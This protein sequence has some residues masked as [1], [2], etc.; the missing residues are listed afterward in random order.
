[1]CIRG[2]CHSSAVLPPLI[3]GCPACTCWPIPLSVLSV[4]ISTPLIADAWQQ[5][6]QAHPDREWISYLITSIWEEFRIGLLSQPRCHSMAGSYPSATSQ[7]EVIAAFLATQVQAGYI[8]GPLLAYLCTGVITSHM[9]VFPKIHL[10]NWT[11][12]LQTTTASMTTL[13]Y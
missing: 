2:S 12:P 7:G 13:I 1:M 9:A 5:T 4:P 11:Y 3:L 10:G 6:L 8:T